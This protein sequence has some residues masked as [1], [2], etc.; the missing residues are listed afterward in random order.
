MRHNVVPL[1]FVEG[2]CKHALACAALTCGFRLILELHLMDA[3]N[4]RFID[5]VHTDKRR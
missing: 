3:P 2:V 5:L 1:L 4:E